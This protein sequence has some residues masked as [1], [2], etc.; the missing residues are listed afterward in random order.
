MQPIEH[1]S[2]APSFKSGFSFSWVVSPELADAGPWVFYVQQAQTQE[3]PWIDMS[4]ALTN[5]YLW[6]QDGPV[7]LPKD[8]ILFYRI[9][10]ITALRTYYSH[11]RTPYADLN[12]ADFLQAREIM[13]NEVVQARH[14]AGILGNVFIKPVTGPKCTDCLDPVTGDVINPDCETCNGTGVASGYHGP[15]QAWMTFSPHRRNKG[16]QQDHL[17]VHEDYEYTVR[18]VGCPIVKKDDVLVDPNSDKR[19]YVNAVHNI[20]ELRRVPLIQQIE[21]R[22]APTSEQIYNLK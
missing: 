6:Q 15:Y 20:M 17:G 7:L 13:R 19:Y 5:A 22:E 4:P 18:I 12:R 1:I 2:I 11:V 8:P 3:G 9:K 16:M 10:L 21:A 14:K